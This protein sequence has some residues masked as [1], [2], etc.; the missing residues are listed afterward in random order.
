[1]KTVKNVVI[2]KDSTLL[3]GYVMVKIFT[4]K[5]DYGSIDLKKSQ[6]SAVEYRSASAG[7]KDKVNTSEG[8]TLFGDL[9]PVMIPVEIDGATISIPKSD[10]SYMVLFVG[11][12]GRLSSQSKETLKRIGF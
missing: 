1:M 9:L 6:V 2:L 11:R 5:S 12:G 7:G 4:L 3:N 10:I 8:S